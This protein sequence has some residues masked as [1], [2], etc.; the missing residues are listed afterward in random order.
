MGR[1]VRGYVLSS[2]CMILLFFSKFAS[3][4]MTCVVLGWHQQLQHART[5]VRGANPAPS[6]NHPTIVQCLCLIGLWLQRPFPRQPHRKPTECKH[7]DQEILSCLDSELQ[8]LSLNR[9][10]DRL[11]VFFFLRTFRTDCLLSRNVSQKGRGWEPAA[12]LLALFDCGS[13]GYAASSA[14]KSK[15][16]ESEDCESSV[17]GVTEQLESGSLWC[18]VH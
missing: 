5:P 6:I 3:L 1:T 10:R 9:G 17:S 14:K 16:L 2:L 4:D 7:R 12:M 13:W 11:L 18:T 15:T 8:N